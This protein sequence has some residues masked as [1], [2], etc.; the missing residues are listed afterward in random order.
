MF[1]NSPSIEAVGIKKIYKLYDKP[2][3]RLKEIVLRK[4]FHKEF[5]AL[6][7]VSFSVEGGGTLGIIGENGAGKSTLLKILARTLSATHGSLETKGRVSSILELG[8]GFHPEFTGIEN[9]YFYGSLLGIGSALMKKKADEIIGF[10]EL[11][12]F[13][14][15]PVKTYSSGMYVRLA[16]SVATAVDPDILIIDEALSVGD[17]YFQRKCLERMDSFRKNGKTVVF[18]SHDMYQIKTFCDRCIWLHNGR[19]EM[20]GEAASVVNA[21]VSHEQVKSGKYRAEDAL[22]HTEQKSSFLFIKDLLVKQNGARGLAIEFSVNSLD[23]FHGHIG[24]AILRKDQLQIS[25]STT[26]MQFKEPVFF[27]GLKKIRIGIKDLNIVNGDYFVYV[28]VFDKQAF[29]P[30]AI[31]SIEC[32]LNT[33]YEIVNSLCHFDSTISVE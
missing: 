22:S 24:W 10:S 2:F 27:D 12:D 15:Y 13:I 8:S 31:E 14:S 4:P 29:K 20:I 32:A 19:M 1:Y 28:G 11:G 6:S 16:F 3:N 30:I 18:C 33:G 7:D 17:Q 26:H 25:F 23:S 5:I 9:I 21:Y